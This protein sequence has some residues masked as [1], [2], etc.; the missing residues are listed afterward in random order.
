[1]KYDVENIIYKMGALKQLGINF[2]ID[3]FGT[4]YSS[5]AYLKRFLL[6]QL[7][8]DKSFIDDINTENDDHVIMETII[9]MGSR[10]GFN[11]IA[12]GLE[13]KEQLIYLKNQG[14]LNY[15]GY[16]FSR[17][18]TVEQFSEKYL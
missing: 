4:G 1:V 11:L 18:L 5:L 3:D 7:K 14:C 10:L 12:K 9:A 6:D 8:I 2:S 17:P 15:Q 13:T 16:Y